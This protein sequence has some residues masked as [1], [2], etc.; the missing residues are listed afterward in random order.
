M[1]KFMKNCIVSLVNN[2]IVNLYGIA[3]LYKLIVVILGIVNS[4]LINRSLG[5]ALR[6]EYTTIISWANFIQLFLNLGIGYAY[7]AIKRQNSEKGKTIFSTIIFILLTIYGVGSVVIGIFID[8]YTRYILIISYI[9]VIE[10]LI[11]LVALIENIILKN[12]INIITA[13]IHTAILL[14]IFT[15]FKYNLH[16][17]L[18]AIIVDHIILGLWLAM[19]NK[20]WNINFIFL[21]KKC[22]IDIFKIAIP[23]MFM[24]ML[25]YLNYHADILFLSMITK[26]SYVVGLY[27]TAVTLGNMLWIIPDAFKD[28]LFHRAAQKDNPEEVVTAIVINIM[29]CL[30]VLISFIICGKSILC[31]M[32]GEDFVSAY[33]LVILLFVGTFPMILYKLIHPIYI[34]NGKTGV[35]VLLLSVAVITNLIGN[36]ILVPMY[37]GVGAAISSIVSYMFC[38][39]VFYIKF[40]HD[41]NVNL[42]ITAMNIVKKF[43]DISKC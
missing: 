23:A 19:I 30:V 29:I 12:R 9:C 18:F 2:K 35:V 27:G 20:M 5:V 15:T 8:G 22:L 21:N 17:V 34:A 28:I 43:F 11:I 13:F 6:G 41:Y 37:S 38:G 16:A 33:T 25:M 31:L 42:F 36:I 40:A 1:N 10:N 3:V 39:I 4:I 32:Y 7:P 26:D 24:N 14:L